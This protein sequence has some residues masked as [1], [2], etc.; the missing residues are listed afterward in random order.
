MCRAEYALSNGDSK[1]GTAFG[2][3]HVTVQSLKIGVPVVYVKL[4]TTRIVPYVLVFNPESTIGDVDVPVELPAS[5][6]LGMSAHELVAVK[7]W[8]WYRSY[9]PCECRSTRNCPMRSS[10]QWS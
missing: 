5:A 10:T 1:V 4:P 2:K 3:D 7:Y 8:T 6:L 9:P